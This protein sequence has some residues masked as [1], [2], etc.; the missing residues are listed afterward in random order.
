[1]NTNMP[2]EASSQPFNNMDDIFS[3]FFQNMAPHP[4]SRP[5]SQGAPM[6]GIRINGVPV[7]FMN[8]HNMRSDPSGV[9]KTNIQTIIDGDNKIEII[10]ET[11]NGISRKKKIITN[12]KTGRKTIITQ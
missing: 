6:G 8:P 5:R 2:R 11:T 7:H 10:T 9:T 1:M 3:M 4:M 12:M